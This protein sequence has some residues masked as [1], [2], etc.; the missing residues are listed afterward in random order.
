MTQASDIRPTRRVLTSHRDG[1]SYVV[2][3]YAERVVVR[4]FGAHRGGPLEVDFSPALLLQ[5]GVRARVDA[6]RA[7]KRRSRRSGQR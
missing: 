6:E 5:Q 7:A 1:K 2:E 4:L 3:L